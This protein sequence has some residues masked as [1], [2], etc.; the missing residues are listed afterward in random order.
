MAHTGSNLDQ[1]IVL[2]IWNIRQRGIA[3]DGI[4]VST[5]EA[6]YQLVTSEGRMGTVEAGP[7]IRPTKVVVRTEL[8]TLQHRSNG[9]PPDNYSVSGRFANVGITAPEATPIRTGATNH[10]ADLRNSVVFSWY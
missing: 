9:S 4:F 3:R 7:G 10:R 1:R 6:T 2:S 8:D 5:F